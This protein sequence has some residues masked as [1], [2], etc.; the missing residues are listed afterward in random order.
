MLR[1]GGAPVTVVRPGWVYGPRDLASFGRFAA[2]VQHGKMV[3]F[4]SGNNQLPL[5]YVR[6]VAEGMLLAANAPDAAGKAYLLVNDEPVTQRAYLGA[7]AAE[8]GVEPPKRKIPYRLALMIAGAA[9]MAGRAAHRTSP[10]PLMRYGIEMLGGNNRFII[11]RARRE[12]NFAPR[13]NLA[14]GVKRSVEWYRGGHV[15][16]HV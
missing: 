2:M 7:I 3:M 6:D 16:Q 1:D 10:P 11:D 8:L 14:E 13:V 15:P 5:V 9:E 12:L 4:G